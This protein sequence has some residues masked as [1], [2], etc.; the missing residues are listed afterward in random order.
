MTDLATL[1]AQRDAALEKAHRHLLTLDGRGVQE[2][3]RI[4]DALLLAERRLALAENAEKVER[5]TPWPP[6]NEESAEYRRGHY[7][8]VMA[9][10]A[11]LRTLIPENAE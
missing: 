1:R 6:D 11:F 7:D 8:G 5:H 10:A 4:L 2:K 9:A 3:G